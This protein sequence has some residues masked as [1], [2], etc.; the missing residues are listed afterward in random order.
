MSLEEFKRQCK[1]K[2]ERLLNNKE[3]WNNLYEKQKVLGG[4][5]YPNQLLK[6]L[7]RF[8]CPSCGKRLEKVYIC[9]NEGYGLYIYKCECGYEF[10]RKER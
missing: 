9:H 3:K 1:D 5:Y 4:Y 8:S 7:Y 2:Y 10:A 6:H